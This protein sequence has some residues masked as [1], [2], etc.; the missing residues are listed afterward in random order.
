MKNEFA[1]RTISNIRD[2]IPS[3]RKPIFNCYDNKKLSEF[4]HDDFASYVL[5][6][7]DLDMNPRWDKKHFLYQIEMLDFI[8]KNYSRV[9][10]YGVW[11]TVSGILSCNIKNNYFKPR[12]RA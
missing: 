10:L 4:D 2:H 7:C 12:K 11:D 8:P 6:H 1:F 5:D 3:K 9:Y